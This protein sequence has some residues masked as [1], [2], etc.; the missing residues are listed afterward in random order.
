MDPPILDERVGE[1][2]GGGHYFTL[3]LKVRLFGSWLQFLVSAEKDSVD[4]DV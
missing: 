3:V 2:I 4:W 1:D